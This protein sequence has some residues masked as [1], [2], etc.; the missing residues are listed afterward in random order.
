MHDLFPKTGTHFSGS[1][2]IRSSPTIWSRH[3]RGGV[4]VATDIRVCSTIVERRQ[5]AR[6]SAWGDLADRDPAKKLSAL[7]SLW[8]S[9]LA[10]LALRGGPVG[11]ETV[12]KAIMR[13][14]NDHT[15]TIA[16]SS[17]YRQ[18]ALHAQP[19]VISMILMP[20][21]VEKVGCA[22]A[23]LDGHVCSLVFLMAGDST[24]W[25]KEK[26]SSPEG[27]LGRMRARVSISS[28]SGQ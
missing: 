27:V 1:C 21:K 24:L 5:R 8:C 19:G 28:R 3:D 15:A 14:A 23:G 11:A 18:S 4:A 13:A 26:M 22:V 20:M 10:Q 25:A 17:A 9:Y 7:E 16:E 2:A 12:A 6:T